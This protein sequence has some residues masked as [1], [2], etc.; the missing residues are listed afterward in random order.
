MAEI[1]TTEVSS[2]RQ[3]LVS[4]VVLETLKQKSVLL[5]TVMDFSQYAQPGA[6]EVKV[7]RRNQFT[8]ATK[9]ENVALTAQELSFSADT[10]S[11]NNHRAIYASLERIA[12]IQAAVNV[13][14][15]I[16]KEMAAELALQVDKDIITELK[17]A[18]AAAPDHRI[19]NTGNIEDDVVEARRLLNLQVVPMMDRYAMFSPDREA[20]LLKVDN[21]IRVDSYGA[22]A[23][24]LVT[25]EI[26]KLFGFTV[27]IHTGLAA[28]ESIYWHKSAV[29]FAQQATPEYQTSFD[30]AKVSQEYLL[31]H[32]MGQKVLDSGKRQVLFNTAGA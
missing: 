5:P 1:G 11:L 22:N 28:D 18:S 23:P 29:G 19:A 14:A 27:L 20:A 26:G 30:L 15:E 31:H 32:L 17:L 6:F 16:L 8:A 13:E 24:A 12:G 3:S 4:A 25:G 10:I 7:P 2:I 21:F 9:T